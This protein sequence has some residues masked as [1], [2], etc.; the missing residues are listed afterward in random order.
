M[1]GWRRRPGLIRR[2]AGSSGQRAFAA[3]TYPSGER[4]DVPSVAEVVEADGA[5][6]SHGASVIDVGNSRVPRPEGGYCLAG[7]VAFEAARDVAGAIT[8][9]P[10]GVGPMIIAVLLRNTVVAATRRAGVVVP[11][12]VEL[13][14]QA[15]SG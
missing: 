4:P 12:P 10:G 7:D 15:G 6:V 9:A 14:L 5:Y 13:L 8:P 3:Q 1:L 2:F 11:D